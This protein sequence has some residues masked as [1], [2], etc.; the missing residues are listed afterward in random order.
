MPKISLSKT[1]SLPQSF[2]DAVDSVKSLTEDS[3]SEDNLQAV[4]AVQESSDSP[5]SIAD[6]ML[7]AMIS[8][9][10][11]AQSNTEDK[12]K[13][14]LLAMAQKMADAGIAVDLDMLALA[15]SAKK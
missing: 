10:Q 13:S 11:T 4:Q 1:I 3:L 12:A 6:V 9:L 8:Y 15:M 5:L 14:K 7:K 2:V